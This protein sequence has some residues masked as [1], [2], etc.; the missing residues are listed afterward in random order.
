MGAGNNKLAMKRFLNLRFLLFWGAIP[1]IFYLAAPYHNTAW[2]VDLGA[3][4]IVI[5][6]HNIAIVFSF[7]PGL[8]G[9]FYLLVE[10]LWRK[11]VGISV[12]RSIAN[13]A[14]TLLTAYLLWYRGLFFDGV[15]FVRGEGM[16]QQHPSLLS[17]LNWDVVLL[18]LFWLTI[19]IWT[20][21]KLLRMVLKGRQG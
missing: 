2:N 21:Q 6:W 13:V 3:R 7:V 8:V 18:L 5:L 10:T 9:L 15:I 1:V 16:Q 14:L 19:E 4:E 20:I 11:Q 17:Y 12:W